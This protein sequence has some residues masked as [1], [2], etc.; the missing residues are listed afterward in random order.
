M[1]HVTS[2]RD[3]VYPGEDVRPSMCRYRLAVQDEPALVVVQV[4]TPR[5]SS[6]ELF[7]AHNARDHLINRILE[8]ELAGMPLATVRL[9]LNA[10]DQRCQIKLD[11]DVE[12]YVRRGNRYTLKAAPGRGDRIVDQI[13]IDSR[14]VIIGRIR[15]STAHSTL[16]PLDPEV[17]SLLE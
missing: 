16:E 14:H 6:V 13:A 15:V 4:D 2:F 5:T 8:H 9:V 3:L 17:A 10:A 1:P 12:D 11:F 7:H